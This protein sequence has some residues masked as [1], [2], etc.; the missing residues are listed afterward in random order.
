MNHRLSLITHWQG[1]EPCILPII[2]TIMYMMMI[3]RGQAWG[4]EGHVVQ[5]KHHMENLPPNCIL[6]GQCW[7]ASIVCY[8]YHRFSEQAV[9]QFTKLSSHKLKRVWNTSSAYCIWLRIVET[10]Q[11]HK[12]K[13]ITC[14]SLWTVIVLGHVNGTLPS[15]A[16]KRYTTTQITHVTKCI[17][18]A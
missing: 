18:R 3:D 8:C 10:N 7:S 16:W 6:S 9:K 1:L 14:I 12:R 13:T 17:Y 4:R 11:S 5:G 2:T 15:S